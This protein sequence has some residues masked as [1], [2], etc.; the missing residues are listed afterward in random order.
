MTSSDEQPVVEQD[1]GADPH[2]GGEALVG[3]GDLA[4][5]RVVLGR[6]VTVCPGVEA[7]RPRQRADADAGSLQVQEHCDRI[8][9]GRA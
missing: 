6:E 5:H 3:R 8:R 2:V 1:P 4:R 7:E 9:V